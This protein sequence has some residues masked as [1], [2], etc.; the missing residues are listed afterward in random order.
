MG[1]ACNWLMKASHFSILPFGG[2]AICGGP[3]SFL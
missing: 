1:G 3:G 2:L